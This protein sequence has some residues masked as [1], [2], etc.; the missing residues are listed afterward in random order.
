M[1]QT[2]KKS[3]I[4]SINMR[5]CRF[6]NEDNW[7]KERWGGV[8]GNDI[9]VNFLRRYNKCKCVCTYQ[10][11]AQNTWRRDWQNRG[12]AAK[13]AFTLRDPN[14]PLVVTD[15]TSRSIITKGMGDLR[16]SLKQLTLMTSLEPSIHKNRVCT[17]SKCVW[18]ISKIRHVWGHTGSQAIHFLFPW[19]RVWQVSGTWCGT[20][21]EPS[22]IKKL[23]GV[24]NL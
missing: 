19:P 18:H 23:F 17:L 13:S 3:C 14:T 16:S 1:V 4:G 15:S 8:W 10:W 20:E 9:R 2:A 6:P 11:R 12:R 24:T 21:V 22:Y 5:K 7:D